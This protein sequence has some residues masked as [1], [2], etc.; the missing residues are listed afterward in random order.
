MVGWDGVL[1]DCFAYLIID[2]YDNIP[3]DGIRLVD[4]V[5]GF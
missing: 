2:A 4:S 5:E 1:D 3:Q